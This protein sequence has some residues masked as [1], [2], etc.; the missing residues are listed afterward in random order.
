MGPVHTISPATSGSKR[1][2]L[3][4]PVFN[5]EESVGLFVSRVEPE[6]AKVRAAM[7]ERATSEIIFVDDGSYDRTVEK[8]LELDGGPTIIKLVKLSRNFGKDAALAAGLAHVSGDAVVPMDVDLQD[9]PELLPDMVAAWLKGFKIVNAVRADRSKDS[10]FKRT[11]AGAFY[12]LFNSLSQFSVPSNVGDFRLMDKQVVEILN[13]MP[14]RVR[15]NKGMVAW[16]GFE[17][18]EV[19]YTRPNREAGVTKWKAWSLWNFALDGITGSSTLPLRIWSYVGGFCAITA[20][21]YSAFIVVRTMIFGVDVPGY[22]SLM[23]VVLTL[24]GLNL[25]AFGILGEYV[26]RIAIEVRRRPLYLVESV[27]E[28]TREPAAQEPAK[29][30]SATS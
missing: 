20:L 22:A 29:E 3:V 28:A 19:H 17:P 5:E 12:K 23:V 26:G 27:S 11:S 4:V 21:L 6:L 2:S 13:Q 25:V 7:G 14:E 30:K 16:L 15:F 10:W 9:P 8:V 1:I 18:A 24:G